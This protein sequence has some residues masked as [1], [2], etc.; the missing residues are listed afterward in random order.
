MMRQTASPIDRAGNV[1]TINNYKPNFDVDATVNPGGDGILIFV[2]LAPP[3]R[4]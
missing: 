3:G 4:D 2:G 1:W